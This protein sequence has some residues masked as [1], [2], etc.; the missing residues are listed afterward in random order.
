M[1]SL[2][3]LV[4]PDLEAV[5]VAACAVFTALVGPLS[6]QRR[7][8][9]VLAGGHTPRRTYEWL[10]SAGCRSGIDWSR[11]EFFW[12]DERAVPPG[13]PESNYRM[14]AET[15]LDPLRID[16]GQIHRM[17]GEVED[18]TAAAAAYEAEIA[19]V[20]GARPGGPPPH[21]DFIFL[22]M[23]ADGH[24]ASL[25]PRT[26]ALHE[27]HRWVVPNRVPQLATTRL[28]MTYPI[29]NNARC[30]VF[31]VTGTDKAPALARVVTT[32]GS[33]DELPASGIRPPSG[34]LLWLADT[35]AAAL[36]PPNTCRTRAGHSETD[37]GE[38]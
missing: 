19:R 13:S 28:T 5:S 20:C 3:L 16:Q 18:L 25:F 1:T 31:L 15:L 7:V 27:Q 32:S 23:G 29:L 24:T 2:P 10:A 4:F 22:G 12:S 34:N 8:A 14:A 26:A 38:P 36:V 35:A 11:V 17:R 6:R 33:T 37:A 30:V 9:V 21:L